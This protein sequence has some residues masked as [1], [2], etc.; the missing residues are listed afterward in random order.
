MRIAPGKVAT[1]HPVRPVITVE[2]HRQDRRPEAIGPVRDERRRHDGTQ[3]REERGRIL[4]LEPA[5]GRLVHRHDVTRSA[6]APWSASYADRRR[7]LARSDDHPGRQLA[8]ADSAAAA[9]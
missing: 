1:Q 5:M 2:Q 9:R 6:L 8:N 4:D 7:R 3:L